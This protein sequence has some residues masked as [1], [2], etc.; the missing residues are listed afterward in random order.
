MQKI[1]T[2]LFVTDEGEIVGGGSTQPECVGMLT[3]PQKSRLVFGAQYTG[4]GYYCH[5]TKMVVPFPVRPHS[6]CLFDYSAKMWVLDITAIRGHRDKLL[7]CSDWTQM[8][9]V[10]LTPEKK[11]EWTAYRQALRDFPET[12]DINN[13]IWPTPPQ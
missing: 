3:P 13:P 11:A 6:W 9:D 10:P 7:E 2:Y 4:T 5:K 12:C 1:T 8:P